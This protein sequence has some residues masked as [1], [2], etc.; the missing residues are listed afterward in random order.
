MSNLTE[1]ISFTAEPR[2][3]E[4]RESS[5]GENTRSLADF[6]AWFFAAPVGLLR[7]A[8][9]Y[10]FGPIRSTVIYREP[11]FQVEMFFFDGSQGFPR[12]HRHPDV[13]AIEMPFQ[14][15]MP[16]ILNGV[17][18]DPNG[19]SVLVRAQ[20]WHG[21]TDSTGGAFYSIQKWGKGIPMTSVGLRW[22]GTPVSE[23]HLK[24]LRAAGSHWV[25][26]VTPEARLKG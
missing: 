8:A 6:V 15:K 2:G 13:D 1:T 24:M 19:K 17:P 26:T 25:K 5:E 11:P 10:N 18:V 12:Q 21:L 4:F 3:A 22:E 23:I 20:D 9:Y 16:F 7:A 14:G